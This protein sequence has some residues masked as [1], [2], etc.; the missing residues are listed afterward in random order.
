M[1]SINTKLSFVLATFLAFAVNSLPAAAE[2]VVVV[3]DVNAALASSKAG[4]SMASQLEGDSF[5][6]TA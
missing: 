3:F 2:Q 5:G 1:T 6:T 4:K